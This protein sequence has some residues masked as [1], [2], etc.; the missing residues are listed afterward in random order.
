MEEIKEHPMNR[1]LVKKAL[2]TEANILASA[3][4]LCLATLTEAVSSMECDITSLDIAEIVYDA[5]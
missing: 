4:S 2:R 3:C 1:L 5:L